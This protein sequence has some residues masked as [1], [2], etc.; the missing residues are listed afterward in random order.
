MSTRQSILLSIALVLLLLGNSVYVVDQRGVAVLLQFDQFKSVVREPGLHF[1]LP[2]A[3]SVEKFD[4]RLLTGTQNDSVSTADQKQLDVSYYLKWRIADVETY[5]RA[6]S[7]KDLFAGDRLMSAVKDAVREVLGH[8]AI[9]QI[10]IGDRDQLD[11]NLLHQA[12]LKAHD[13][14]IEVVDLRLKGLS[15]PHDVLEAY[16][17]RMR[18][19]R[20][21]MAEAQRARGAEEAEAIKAAADSEAQVAVAE[22]YRKSE[23]LRGEGDGKAAEIYAKSYGQDPEFYAFYG[24]LNAYRDAFKGRRDVLVVEPKGEFFKYFK[25]AGSGK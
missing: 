19:E 9:D 2:L 11:A 8:T 23:A 7:G 10:I 20:H 17:E 6:T 13:L 3:E 14:G 16:F 22:A 18:S 15:L 4:R 1:K 21:A 25:D 12:Q 5:Y 24:S